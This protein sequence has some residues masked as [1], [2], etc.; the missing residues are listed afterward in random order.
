MATVISDKHH[1]ISGDTLA[2]GKVIPSWDHRGPRYPRDFYQP[3]FDR[4]LD[5]TPTFWES[6]LFQI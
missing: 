3:D 5:R 4:I 1:H 6:R 2:F